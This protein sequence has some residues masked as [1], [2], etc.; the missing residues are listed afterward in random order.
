MTPAA[1]AAELARH[2]TAIVAAGGGLKLRHP[3]GQP[4]PAGL[5]EAARA[6]RAALISLATVREL[7]A[8]LARLPETQPPSGFPDERWPE[9]L[10][11]ALDFCEEWAAPALALGWSPLELFGLHPTAPATRLDCK[12]LAF[13]VRPGARVVA[14]TADV[15][16]IRTRTGALLSHD[17][18]TVAGA[19]LAWEIVRGELTFVD[20]FTVKNGACQT[21]RDR[22]P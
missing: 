2:G 6:H 15:A 14:I 22:P 19:M 4:P 1:I 5:I 13:V 21:S 8:S 18:R 16:T 11:S 12:G 3:P 20:A 7:V 17:R 9:A 10:A